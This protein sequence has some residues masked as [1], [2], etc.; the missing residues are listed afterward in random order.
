MP[1]NAT[2]DD[3]ATAQSTAWIAD[4]TRALAG[5]QT[6]PG[7]TENHAV[8]PRWGQGTA[9]LDR[10]RASIAQHIAGLPRQGRPIRTSLRGIS[11]THLVL[12]KLL[13]WQLAEPAAAVSAAVADVEVIVDRHSVEEVHIHLVAVGTEPRDTTYLH[14][15]DS[16]REY[17]AVVIAELIGTA[18]RITLTWEDVALPPDA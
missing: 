4:A 11:I 6:S 17:A 7:D 16:L 15:G 8:D 1:S 2:D 18:P 3:D 13:T 9:A 14:D 12:A 5:L 10:L